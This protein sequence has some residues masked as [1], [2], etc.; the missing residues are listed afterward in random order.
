MLASR[1]LDDQRFED[2]V[3]EARGR[4]PWLCPEWTDHNA[5]DPG[6]TV[7]EL[8]AW[9]KEMQQ[10]HMDQVTPAIQSRLLALAGVELLPARA[11]RCA[12]RVGEDCPARLRLARLT[13]RQDVSFELLEPIPARRARLDRVL[14]EI[15][16]GRQDVSSMM[17]GGLSFYPFS[18][19]GGE[20]SSLLLG[21][22]AVPE[23][24]VRLW[25]QVDCPAGRAPADPGAPPP[26][27]LRWELVGR[28]EE[29]PLSDGTWSLSQSGFVVLPAADW[30]RGEE[31]LHWLRVRLEE[32]GCEERVRLSRVAAGLYGAAQQETRARSDWFRLEDRAGQRVVIDHAPA[33]W[34]ELAVFL[35]EPSGWRQVQPEGDIPGAEGRILMVDGRGSAQDGAD[36][37]TVVCLDPV[38]LP[39]LLFDTKGRPGEELCL[40]LAGQR[41]LEGELTL[42]CHTLERD[43]QVRPA[44][45]RC[46]EDLS[47]CGPRD[48]VFQYDPGR[49]T[50]RFGDGLHGAVPVAGKGSV[51]VSGLVLSRGG[52]GNIPA[53]AQL[54]FIQGGWPAENEPASGGRDRETVTEA[55]SRLLRYLGSTQKCLSARDFEDRARE[56]PGLLVAAARALPGYAGPGQGAAWREAVVTVVVLP[57]SEEPLPR[58][59]GR[60]LQAVQ[61]QLDRCRPVC[62]QARAAGPQY[63][64]LSLSAQLR[65]EGGAGREGV[66]RALQE[67][68][69]PRQELIG[70]PVRQDDVTACL[71]RAPGVLQV[72]RIEVQSMGAGGYRTRSGDIQL[73][74]DGIPYWKDW[75]LELVR[76]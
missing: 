19:G 41:P 71:Q 37:L 21:F 39:D 38:R 40:N 1:R 63:V 53:S 14:V 44:Q 4:L 12:I 29:S 67:L 34:G 73:P 64:P 6:I 65:V 68:F 48:R 22:G 49:E 31:G 17:T 46:V 59:D 25:F 33:L 24:T 27:T 8:M 56:T 2:I 30:P 54:V 26:R 20:E 74:P 50:V 55:R 70:T 7:L 60:F 28:G 15:G 3:Q 35:R 47:V 51:L 76:A 45:W 5:H 36:N 16:G 43:G 66:E 13:N 61:R 69:R 32:A 75:K 9:Y 52:G 58:P 57:V 11:A 10:Y 42:M 18:F 72:R 23:E 62:V